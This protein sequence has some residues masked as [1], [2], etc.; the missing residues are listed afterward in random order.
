[1]GLCRDQRDAR[2]ELCDAL[3]E[4]PYVPD[5]NPAGFDADFAN[6]TRPNPYF[7]LGIGHRWQ[8]VGGDETVTVE[9]LDKTKLISSRTGFERKYYARGIGLFLEVNPED[10]EIVQLVGCNVDPKCAALPAP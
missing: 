2:L 1:V 4:G 5:F 3:G 8:Y 9:V 7:P 10:G 6:L